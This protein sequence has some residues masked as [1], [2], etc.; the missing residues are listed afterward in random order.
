MGLFSKHVPAEPRDPRPKGA[1]FDVGH[2]RMIRHLSTK[3][4][5]RIEREAIEKERSRWENGSDAA[6][7]S[8]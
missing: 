4:G 1:D 5:R 7:W 2:I 3:E 8:A 6:H